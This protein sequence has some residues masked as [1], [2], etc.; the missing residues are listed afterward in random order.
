MGDGPDV[1]PDA[2]A[3]E[4]VHV[5]LADHFTAAAPPRWADEGI[6]L[7]FDGIAKQ[8]RHEAD[9]RAA[10]SRGLAFSAADLLAIEHYPVDAARQR[11]FYGQSAALVRWLIA[12]RDAATFI[13][14]VADAQSGDLP[15]AFERHYGLEMSAVFDSAWKEV[16]PIHSLSFNDAKN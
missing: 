11:V 4:L 15:A 8:A 12:R 1:I 7:L 6:A 13:R 9:F 5:V 2:L 10:L 14:F 3:H 16:P